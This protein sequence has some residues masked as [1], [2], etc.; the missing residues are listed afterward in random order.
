MAISYWLNFQP[1]HAIRVWGLGRDNGGDFAYVSRDKQTR[2]HMCHV[3]R[4]GAPFPIFPDPPPVACNIIQWF[5]F[6]PTKGG[7]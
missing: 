3:F 4:Y 2:T 6:G 7:H 1:I 5:H